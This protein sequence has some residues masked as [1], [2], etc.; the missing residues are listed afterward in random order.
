M[1]ICILFN[2]A[3]MYVLFVS[4]PC[5]NFFRAHLLFLALFVMA[6]LC[7]LMAW[8]IEK[9]VDE[10]TRDGKQYLSLESQG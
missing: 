2:F 8:S 5:C 4:L 9:G 6:I 3:C 1:R 7:A 10:E